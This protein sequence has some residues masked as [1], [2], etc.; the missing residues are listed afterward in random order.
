MSQDTTLSARLDLRWLGL[1]LPFILLLVSCPG[2]AQ[3][4]SATW[5]QNPANGDWNTAAN[6]TPRTIP[7]SL[8]AIATF[9]TS[10]ITDVS[11]SADTQVGGIVFDQEA[12]T[13]TIEASALDPTNQLSIGGTG[14]TNRSGLTQNFV[15]G[16]N[17]LLVFLN[18]ATAGD[19]VVYAN[20]GGFLNFV[21]TANAGS[22]SIVN[23][24]DTDTNDNGGTLFFGGASA[25]AAVIVNE[26]P[27]SGGTFGGFTSF[28]DRS[29]AGTST[30]TSYAAATTTFQDGASAGAATLIADGG[31][32]YFT[33][34]ST[35]GTARL[36][37]LEF[38][39]LDLTTRF[40]G[41]LTI[42]SLEGDGS[43]FLGS[44]N[45]S[46]G[47]NSLST[48][49]SGL[50]ADGTANDH[51]ALTK[52]GNGSLALTGA[53]TYTGDTTVTAGILVVANPTGLGT[54]TG[55][56]QVNGGTLGGS[57]I[58]GG[59]TTIGAGAFLAPAAGSRKQT[60]LTMQSALTFNSDSTYTCTFKAKRNKGRAD[61]VIANGVTI[62]GS[63][64]VVLNG[65]TQGQLTQGLT[66]TL[67]TNT[68]ANPI[69]GTF[70]NLPD[71]GIVTINGNNFQANYEGGNGNDL[72]LTV[73]P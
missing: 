71:G 22:S 17:G 28:Q 46:I 4:G 13:F 44:T 9:A 66:L 58:I 64:T 26:G 43:V 47:S 7:N 68:S 39:Q 11:I 8:S 52:L 32:I 19:G 35:G 42:G 31:V 70:S 55:A 45:L 14:V 34:N 3:A 40:S 57:G 29:T 5:N 1:V 65:Q 33:G 56:L 48:I 53:N 16:V 27:E 63:A 18:Q 12:G 59:A 15:S 41:P 24:G 62:N 49:F 73:V 38:G 60:T 69:N 23:S 50:V 67:I 25:A 2:S 54:G 72:T 61:R 30:I 20:R 37:L 36:E 6:W 21:N 51:G 10:S